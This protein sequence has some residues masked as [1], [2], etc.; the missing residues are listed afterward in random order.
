L[1]QSGF[2]T[3][4]TACC[5]V[6]QESLHATEETLNEGFVVA[7]RRGESS[8]DYLGESSI[9]VCFVCCKSALFFFP[10]FLARNS[11]AGSGAS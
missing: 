9:D 2:D 6:Q 1:V 3:L 4:S 11:L 7:I 5:V 8:C 10:L